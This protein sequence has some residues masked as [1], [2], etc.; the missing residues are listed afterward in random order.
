MKKQLDI[1][2]IMKKEKCSWEQA[3]K[4]EKEVKQL[5]DFF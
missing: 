3:V 5:G 1:L 2:E 4:K